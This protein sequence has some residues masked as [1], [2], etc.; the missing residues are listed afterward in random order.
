[1][2]QAREHLGIATTSTATDSIGTLNHPRALRPPP[3]RTTHCTF[4]RA[5]VSTVTQ[6]TG[7]ART[8]RLQTLG[9]VWRATNAGSSLYQIWVSS[10]HHQSHSSRRPSHLSELSWIC[11]RGVCPTSECTLTSASAWRGLGTRFDL[12]A[13]ARSRLGG[14]ALRADVRTTRH[15]TFQGVN[16]L[17]RAEFEPKAQSC[18]EFPFSQLFLV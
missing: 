16:R 14:A 8:G 1:M 6:H 9:A 3:N 17:V 12:P 11:R 13:S 10:R 15:R 2:P 4:G 7:V 18:A 5:Q